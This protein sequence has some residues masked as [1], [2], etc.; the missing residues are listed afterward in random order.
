MSLSADE[1]FALTHCTHWG[2]EAYPVVRRGRSWFVDGI[3]GCGVFPNTFKTKRAAVDQWE[4]YLDI[5][6]ERSQAR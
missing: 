4:R 5:L 2:A 6:I 3:R 1:R